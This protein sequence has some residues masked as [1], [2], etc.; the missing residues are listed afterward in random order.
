MSSEI[1]TKVEKELNALFGGDDMWDTDDY[2]DSKTKKSQPMIKTS[3]NKKTAK[4][5][6]G[7][8]IVED[9]SLSMIAKGSKL[10]ISYE[11]DSDDGEIIEKKMD[12]P[13]ELKATFEYLSPNKGRKVDNSLAIAAYDQLDV[14]FPED[15]SW[16]LIVFYK[17]LNAQAEVGINLYD[18]KKIKKLFGVQVNQKVRLFFDRDNNQLLI[19]IDETKITKMIRPNE[20]LQSIY[21]WL[22]TNPKFEDCPPSS[23]YISKYVR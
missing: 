9:A 13:K 4:K 6:F 12:A 20:D 22:S 17:V 10:L 21:D 8:S 15:D 5:L 11:E 14:L 16:K 23:G 2:F 1:P 18:I 3:M 19:K 7:V